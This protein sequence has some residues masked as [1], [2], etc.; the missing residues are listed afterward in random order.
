MTNIMQIK[1][2]QNLKRTS[3]NHKENSE[4]PNPSHIRS[5]VTSLGF[6]PC[7]PRAPHAGNGSPQSGHSVLLFRGS[8]FVSHLFVDG[9]NGSFPRALPA[10]RRFSFPAE[11]KCEMRVVGLQIMVVEYFE[12]GGLAT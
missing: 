1:H 7:A 8:N 2:G 12:V 4:A 11:G 5:L 3:L 6:L 9:V 10:L